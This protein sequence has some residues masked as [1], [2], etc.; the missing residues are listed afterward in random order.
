[1]QMKLGEIFV[2]NN[3]NAELYVLAIEFHPGI[4]IV[5]L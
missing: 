3:L 2:K 4:E 1:M 5:C